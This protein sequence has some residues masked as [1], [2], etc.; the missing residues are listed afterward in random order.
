M[1]D[2]TVALTAALQRDLAGGKKSLI[3]RVAAA[4]F[5]D[6]FQARTAKFI[7]NNVALFLDA[8]EAQIEAGENKL[9]W[10]AAYQRF[11]EIFDGTLS[12]L[13]AAEGGTQEEF[14]AEAERV[15][16]AAEAEGGSGGPE[17]EFIALMQ[18]ASDYPAFLRMM[19]EEADEEKEDMGAEGKQEEEDE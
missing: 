15:M 4:C 7:D 14:E 13:L 12:E 16:A 10:Y 11:M 3:A 18:A 6:E 8:T 1:A 9:E 5:S 17:A 19:K 2:D